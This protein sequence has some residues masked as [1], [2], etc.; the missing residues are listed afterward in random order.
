MT[1]ASTPNG[2]GVMN[3]RPEERAYVQSVQHS[4]LQP[5]PARFQTSGLTQ[6]STPKQTIKDPFEAA[7]SA[8]HRAKTELDKLY[9][10]YVTQQI[11]RQSINNDVRSAVKKSI[12]PLEK[13]KEN[14]IL[15]GTHVMFAVKTST[16]MLEH[17]DGISPEDKAEIK[18]DI[19]LMEEAFQN[20]NENVDMGTLM[21]ARLSAADLE[22]TWSS[23]LNSRSAKGGKRTHRKHR[24]HRKRT[25]R[26]RTHRKHKRTQRK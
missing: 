15:V 14:M 8:A 9:E 17:M 4:R 3:P 24:T 16:S 2:F 21:Y 23:Y 25:H 20:K 13:H 7:H 10:G 22:K 26:K 11:E 1:F 18:E 5:L 6:Y 19:K 12:Y